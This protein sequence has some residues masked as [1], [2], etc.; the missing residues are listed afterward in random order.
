[1]EQ[2]PKYELKDFDFIRIST[3]DLNGCHMTKLVS[4]ELSQRIKNNE[5]DLYGGAIALGPRTQYVEMQEFVDNNTKNAFFYPDLATLKPVKWADDVERGFT[6]GEVIADMRWDVDTPLDFHPRVVAKRQIEKLHSMDLELYSAFE[7]EFRA[8]KMDS[9][10]PYSTGMDLYKTS[11]LSKYQNF[12]MDSVKKLTTAGIGIQDCSIEHG[13][14]QLEMPLLP[15]HGIAA[16][17]EAFRFKQGIKEIGR[18]HKISISFMTK[19]FLSESSSGNHFNHSL[20]YR[21]TK[22]NAMY[23]PEGESDFYIILYLCLPVCSGT[24]RCKICNCSKIFHKLCA[25]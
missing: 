5:V 8:F 24:S 25:E 3:P 14:G 7:P 13:E 21:S 22:K 11:L 10:E 17:D 18:Q 16:A 4:S 15:S 6:V 19:P 23:D 2:S 12:F 1:M 20:W 9:Y